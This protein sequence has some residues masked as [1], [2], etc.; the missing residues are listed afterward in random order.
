MANKIVARITTPKK[1]TA[2]LMNAVEYIIGP[3]GPQG[4]KGDS[5]E[6]NWDGSNLGIR[7]E[8]QEE[9][10]YQDLQG[11]QG[12]Q[13]IPGEK[14]ETGEQGPQGEQG[15]QGLPGEQGETGEQGIQGIPGE[16]GKDALINGVNTLTI[17]EGNNIK[18]TQHDN[19]LR[20]DNTYEYNDTDIKTNIKSLE[21]LTGELDRDLSNA[22]NDIEA[23]ETDKADRTEIPDVSEFI[24][25]TVDD[26]TNYYLKS[27]TYTQ[28]EVNQLIGAI[29]T[30][31]MKV[32]PTR[33]EIGETN[34]IYL[35][36]S[37]KSE[38]EN[39]Y[40]EWIYVDSKWELIGSTKC[41]LSNYYTKDEINTI[42]FDYIT[43]TDL[44]ETLKDYASKNYVDTSISNAIGNIDTLLQDL[45]TGSG[46]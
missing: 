36:P 41:D 28:T 12:I 34:I 4:P 9:Y 29:K 44:E 3:E 24:K 16:K 40:E 46:V 32:L 11:P 42:L 15:I 20:I 31:S 17:Q 10:E 5:L 1:V 30:I 8:G 33:P 2:R 38:T 37:T 14:G 26:L 43:S 27:E 23:L 35:I 6:F 19:T 18:L 25:K 7:V 39:I 13:G 21:E 22:I 45:D